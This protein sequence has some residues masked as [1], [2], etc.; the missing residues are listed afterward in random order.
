MKKHIDEN[1][2]DLIDWDEVPLQDGRERLLGIGTS[3]NPTIDLIG[4]QDELT[5]VGVTAVFNG[6]GERFNFRLVV[7][8]DGVADR[9]VGT[10]GGDWVIQRIQSL[11]GEPKLRDGNDSVVISGRRLTLTTYSATNIANLTVTPTT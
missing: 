2:D 9:I 11:S 7:V 10:E 4:P 6:T 5:E 8:F 3:D 1:L